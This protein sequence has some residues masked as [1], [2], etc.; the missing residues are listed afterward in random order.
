LK[1]CSGFENTQDIQIQPREHCEGGT[2]WTLAS[3]RPRVDSKT[4]RSARETIDFLQR[5]YQLDEADV[6]AARQVKRRA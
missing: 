5:S 2:N 1:G 4:L 3:V 6:V